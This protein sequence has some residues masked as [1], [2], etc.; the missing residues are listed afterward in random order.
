MNVKL[1]K[2]I[3]K[4]NLSQGS[5]Y[6]VIGI[7]SNDFRI[8]DNDNK[9][10]LYRPNL[11]KI[12]NKNEPDFW[13]TEYGNEGERYSYPKE[14]NKAGF[15]EDLFDDDIRAK[16][17]FEKVLKHYYPDTFIKFSET[18]K[19]LE[20]F[21]KYH[22]NLFTLTPWYGFELKKIG[23]KSIDLKITFKKGQRYCCT[24]PHCHLMD[25][26]WLKLDIDRISMV[27]IMFICEKGSLIKTDGKYFKNNLQ[28]Y[29]VRYSR[30]KPNK[31]GR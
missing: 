5:V 10:Y 3:N 28:S 26:N 25:I 15:F 30:N 11:F 22:R 14:I 18:K 8:L 31:K 16:H 4:Y 21:R 23:I 1:L 17:K 12:I 7:G 19:V 27:N 6:E 2:E 20:Y 24:E 9:P 29:S 13:I